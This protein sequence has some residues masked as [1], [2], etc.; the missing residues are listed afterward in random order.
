MPVQSFP[1]QCLVGKASGSANMLPRACLCASAT[2]IVIGDESCKSLHSWSSGAFGELLVVDASTGNLCES[3]AG[4]PSVLLLRL[5]AVEVFYLAFGVRPPRLTVVRPPEIPAGQLSAMHSST[6]VT[7]EANIFNILP[8]LSSA[9]DSPLL[10]ERECW[11]AL[12]AGGEPKLPYLYAAYVALRSAGW[13]IRDG[14]K[15]GVHFALYSPLT[16]ARKQHAQLHALVFTQEESEKLW[17][18]LQRHARV[19]HGVGKGLL[20]CSVAGGSTAVARKHRFGPEQVDPLLVR[21]LR[22]DGWHPDRMHAALAP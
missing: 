1:G 20:L 21:T 9:A 2:A 11:D 3:K 10:G 18:W 6:S 4:F 22:I 8:M 17:I 14:I 16:T 5:H 19:S 12:V 7:S 15:F 13:V